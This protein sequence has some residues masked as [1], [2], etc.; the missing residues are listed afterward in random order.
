MGDLISIK[1]EGKGIEKFWETVQYWSSPWIDSKH[2]K[3]MTEV[4][5]ERIKRL[6]DAKA[7]DT[8]VLGDAK[9][10]YETN[11]MKEIAKAEREIISEKELANYDLLQRAQQRFLHDQIDNQYNIDN[12]IFKSPKYL[13]VDVSDEPV[14][15]EWTKRFFDRAKDISDEEVQETWAKIL[16][17]EVE[18]PGSFDYRT[19]DILY[20]LTK[21]EAE[22]FKKIANISYENKIYAWDN[23]FFLNKLDIKFIDIMLMKDIGLLSSES[24][25]ANIIKSS[26]EVGFEFNNKLLMIKNIKKKELSIPSMVLTTSGIQLSN[27]IEKEY[28]IEYLIHFGKSLKK[29]KSD[30]IIKI[31][32]IIN[33]DDETFE[34][35]DDKYIEI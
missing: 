6:A 33:T 31:Y 1:L 9:I 11:R 4:E 22:I 19:L 21:K 26:D 32:D 3:K 17:G 5:V 7:Y 12:V 28:Q 18:K 13:T 8:K 34:Y 10:E 14:N 25:V 20:N 35:D 16:A 27:L 23:D 2:L 24:K 30:L 15:K 29:L